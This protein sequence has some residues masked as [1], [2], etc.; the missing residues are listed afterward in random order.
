MNPWKRPADIIALEPR[1]ARRRRARSR[2]RTTDRLILWAVAGLMMGM[3]IVSAVLN[4]EAV[5]DHLRDSVV[6]VL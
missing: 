3:M 4:R 6:S 5:F 2:R 1:L